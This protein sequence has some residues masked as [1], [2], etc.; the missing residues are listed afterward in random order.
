MLEDGL[1]YPTRGDW[2]R[3]ILLGGVLGLFSPV[4]LPAFVLTGYYVRVLERTAGGDDDPP[5]FDD[6]GD[7]LVTGLVGTVVAAAYAVVP[8]VAYLFVVGGLF[9][10]GAGIGGKSGGLLAG[11][12]VLTM[13]AFVP[14]GLLIYYVVPAALANYAHEDSIGAAFDLGTLRPVLVSGE[15]LMAA[16]LPLAVVFLVG[17][18][19]TILSMTIVGIVLVPFVGFYANVVIFRMFGAAFAEA[20]GSDASRSPRA[21]PA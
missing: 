5:E 12:G 14:L 21:A 20:S 7:L 4:V 17:I 1:S 16:I 15:Y 11:I 18:A 9:G 10:V 3:R 8:T 13:L 19:T 2:L 6:W